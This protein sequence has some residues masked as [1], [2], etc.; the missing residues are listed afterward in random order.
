[1]IECK[2]LGKTDKL[3]NIHKFILKN[4]NGMRVT[5]S[6]FGALVLSIALNDRE[7]I[8]RDVALGFEHIEDYYDTETGMGAYVGR[9]ANRIKNANVNIEGINYTL[10]ANEGK[11]NI[12]SGF[13]RSHCQVYS[14]KEGV[15]SDSEYIELYR[16][17]PHL[18][19]GFP[20]NLEQT[21]RYIVTDN[22]EFIIEYE[23]PI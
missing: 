2:I 11:N 16:V 6:D 14:F 22:N 21:I 3:E 9:N 8:T 19:Q 5:V 18:E 10:E 4:K 15:D 13:N 23:M 17:S 20:G 7:G 12:H 1:M